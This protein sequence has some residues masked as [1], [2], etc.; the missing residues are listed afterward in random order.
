MLYLEQTWG[1]LDW[2]LWWISNMVHVAFLLVTLCSQEALKTFLCF[3]RCW[4][5]RWGRRG[6][7][8]RQGANMRLSANVHCHCAE[9]RPEERRR[10][11]RRSAEALQRGACTLWLATHIGLCAAAKR[12]VWT[13]FFSNC[14]F[15]FFLRG[16]RGLRVFF[17]HSCAPSA[18]R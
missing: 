17:P 7:R 15:C 13:F 5:F 1:G 11:R 6:R 3:F 14:C 18:L 8:E 9:S 12:W 2:R 10:S 4:R 16:L